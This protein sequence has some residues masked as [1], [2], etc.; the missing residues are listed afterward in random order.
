MEVSLPSQ[1]TRT[2]RF[3]LGAPAEFTLV[4][5]GET[6][7]FLRSRAGDDPA[8][9]LWALNLGTGVERLLADPVVLLNAE[10]ESALGIA[11]YAT[12]DAGEL[13]TFSLNGGLW[14]LNIAA[15]RPRRL[16]AAINVADPRPDPAGQRIAYVSDGALRVIEA[17]GSED[18]VIAEPEE[19]DVTYGVA[20]HTGAASL[21]G[22]RGYWWSPDGTRL[23]VAQVDSSGVDLWHITD[24][25]EPTQPPRTVRYAAAGQ[26]NA[27]VTL[28][29]IGVD[30]SRTKVVWDQSAFEYV[31]G[32][33]WDNHGPY[34]LVQSRDRGTVQ[35]LGID[36]TG[37]TTVLSEQ[38]DE[39]WVQLIPGLPS[40]TASGAL[41]DHADWGDIRP[42]CGR[43]RCHP[44]W[45]AAAG[46]ARGGW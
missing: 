31:P 23:L 4:R 29:L 13:V 37:G 46:R 6:V 15:G 28:W 8:T 45:S 36:P 30:G 38:R 24:P 3:T 12:D 40:R 21:G 10:L 11:A 34:A 20:E 14:A 19:P 18:R 22:K 5:G 25:A 26:A 41:L 39:C 44:T 33:G 43:G 7:L 1:L 42:E 16:R 32:A 2:R 17:E 35:F 9:C 27:E